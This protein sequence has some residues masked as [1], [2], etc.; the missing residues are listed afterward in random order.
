M[1]QGR[2][3]ELRRRMLQRSLDGL[4][5][6]SLPNV[7]YLTG[8]SGSNGLLVLTPRQATLLS[9]SRYA[10]QI[11]REVT[12][13]RALISR[14]D[15]IEE[16]A[17]ALRNFRAA[18]FESQAITHA[19]F[20]V[21]RRALPGRALLATTDLVEEI[22]L[23]KDRSEQALIARAASISDSVFKEV[24]GEIRPGVR[25]LDVASEISWLTR[26]LGAEADAFEVIVASGSH[27]ALPHARASARRIRSGEMV[28]LDF[29][30]KVSGYSSDLTRTVA[31]HRA[32][33]RLQN[34][35]RAVQEAQELA[36]SAAHAGM[37]AR[38]LD[39]V[40]RRRLEKDGLGKYFIHSLGH[41][42]GL[43]IHEAPKISPLSSE[44]LRAGSVITIEPGVY[45]PG[46][47]GVRIEDDVVLGA[48]GCRRLTQAPRELIFV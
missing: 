45:I 11:G 18:G 35:Y 12:V 41:G 20:R 38:E 14:R 33:R 24:L 36:I 30:A 25:E 22:A 9:D 23:V 28:V 13:A 34:V 48:K 44:T 10:H 21:L 26:R 3:R 19:Q 27:A 43:R 31:V 47:G 32:G 5:V 37:S 15:L 16:A 29:G 46:T 40:A 4:L 17:A 2:I 42:L 39:A 7:R 8:F 6:S 1:F